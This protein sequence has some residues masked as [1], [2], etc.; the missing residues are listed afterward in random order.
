M[1]WRWL[2]PIFCFLALV[3]CQTAV[4]APTPIVPIAPTKNQ[5]TVTPAPTITPSPVPP[6]TPTLPAPS[7]VPDTG[8]EALQPGLERRI[9]RLEE[10]GER[11]S[12]RWP[13]E[14]IYLL[15]LEPEQFNFRIGYRPGQPQPLAAWQT[16]TDALIVLNGGFFTEEFTATG[17]IVADGAA[18]GVSYGD[19]AGM[20]AIA[21]AG[22]ELRWLA[23]R[24]YSPTE[25][26]QFA[27]QSFPVLVKPGGV[28]GYPD[29]DGNSARRTVI[30]LDDDGRFLIILTRQGN[31]TLH[32][33]SQWL[34]NSDLGLDIALNLDGGPSSGLI[35]AEP[36]EEFL[37]FT[38]LP[39]VITIQKK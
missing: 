33:L 6:N 23:E 17:L 3:G 21:E 27:L 25:P 8:W 13:S 29:E 4:S 31:F 36:R 26:L 20:L 18:S 14:N 37:A 39:T 38:P 10:S 32:Q 35:L 12:E 28:L 16:E 19:F 7:P 9:V 24:P 34:T 15:R 30:G 5:P 2:L 11:P 1:R 22:P